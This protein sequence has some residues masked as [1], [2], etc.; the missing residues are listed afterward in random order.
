MGKWAFSQVS[1][2][3]HLYNKLEKLGNKW[4]KVGFGLS[5]VGRSRHTSNISN[6]YLYNM[7][8]YKLQNKQNRNCMHHMVPKEILYA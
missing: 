5:K 1:R 6:I 7:G 2:S 8:P 4:E 3:N